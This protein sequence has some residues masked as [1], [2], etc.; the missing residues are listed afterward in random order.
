MVRLLFI[1]VGDVMGYVF[2]VAHKTS[3]WANSFRI[4]VMTALKCLVTM[5]SVA[6]DEGDIS[7]SRIIT[8][9]LF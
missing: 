7:Y 4:E 2:G 6:D 3:Y 1:L 5:V 8:L 9:Y